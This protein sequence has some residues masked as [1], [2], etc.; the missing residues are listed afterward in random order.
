[1]A[2]DRSPSPPPDAAGSAPDP[3]A[4]D[5]TARYRAMA[6]LRA[7]AGHVATG[8]GRYFATEEAVRQGLRE[9]D[10]FV[11]S[12]VD[13]SALPPDEVI[14]P[15][16]PEPEHGRLRAVVNSVIAARHLDGVLPFVRETAAGLVAAAVAAASGGRPVDLVE[17]LADPLPTVVIAHVLGVSA[18]DRDRFRVWSDELLAAQGRS[19]DG[20]LARAHPEFAAYVQREIDRR[21]AAADPPDDVITRLIRS[22]SAD[23]TRLS[24]AAV[25]TQT[26]FLIVAG[27]ETTRNLI[28]NCLRTLAERPDLYAAVRADPALV[29]VVV[30]ESL[31]HDSPVQIL[32]RQ[33]LRGGSL[34]GCPVARGE[35]VVFGIASA[36]R[37]EAC[38]ADADTFRLDRPYPR[39]HLAFGT[40][41][42]VCP[43]AALARAE[44]TALLHELCGQVESLELAP[45]FVARPNPVFWALG[46]RSLPCVVTPAGEAG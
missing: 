41:A 6:D 23:G 2:T 44:A 42:H 15:A 32:A 22:E 7:G 33:A 16:V 24:G 31:R 20:D 43:G 19:S 30:E 38:H 46:Q 3:L 39:D 13:T 29:A 8:M 9:V 4:G 14:L 36:N 27:N 26:M 12:M 37:D 25:R 35:R 10:R 34:G 5:I 45:D 11:G 18:D 28:G 17:A 21:R 40:G 1:M